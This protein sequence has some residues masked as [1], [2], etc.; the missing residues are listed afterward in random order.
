MAS[1]AVI[2]RGASHT[3]E[4]C[5]HKLTFVLLLD[6][7]SASLGHKADRWSAASLLLER[8]I[9]DFRRTMSGPMGTS[10]SQQKGGGLG[11]LDLQ[12]LN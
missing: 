11:I 8:G 1:K 7:Q 3:C 2:A 12:A 10:L 5:S 9:H 4:R 6:L